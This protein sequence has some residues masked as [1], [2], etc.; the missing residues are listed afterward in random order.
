MYHLKRK[1]KLLDKK[2]C[3]VM[4]SNSNSKFLVYENNTDSTPKWLVTLERTT[5]D[6]CQVYTQEIVADFTQYN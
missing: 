1:Y 5:G 6:T 4:L 2:G 3:Y